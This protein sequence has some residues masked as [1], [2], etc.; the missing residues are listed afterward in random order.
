MCTLEVGASS[1][2][3]HLLCTPPP[4]RPRP[5]HM[6]GA[7]GFT[8]MVRFLS[9]V[10]AQMALQSLKVPEASAT[11]FTGVRLLSSVDEHVGTEV[12]HL[13]GSTAQRERCCLPMAAC[14][15]PGLHSPQG[16]FAMLP[17]SPE[18]TWPHRFHICRAFLQSEFE[19]GSSG[20]LAD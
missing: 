15:W 13:K 7:T 14:L 19:C 20:W 16:P 11:D 2:A 17:C 3:V 12:G 18:Q 9:C 8:Y 6:A 1:S 5:G 4:L 10:D